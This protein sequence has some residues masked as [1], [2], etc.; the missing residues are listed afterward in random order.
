MEKILDFRCTYE[1]SSGF[2][3]WAA[4]V[5]VVTFPQAYTEH[6]MMM[7]LA[8]AVKKHNHA[9]LC[10]LPFC[11]TL[12]AEALGGKI[13][14]GDAMTGPRAASCSYRSL[15][16]IQ[17]L[18]EIDLEKDE[19]RR[20]KESLEACRQLEKQGE[21]VLFLVSGPFTIL[22]SLVDQEVLFR[23]VMKKKDLVLAVFQKLGRDIRKVMKLAEEAGVRY[24]S[25]G[26]PAGGVNIVGPKVAA[27]VAKEFT[28]SFLRE[29]DRELQP[30]TMVL[31]CPKTALA[32][33]GSG[34]AEWREWRLPEP[35]EYLEAA[36]YLNGEHDAWDVVGSA[37]I[38]AAGI[39]CTAVTDQKCGIRFAGQDC[40][41]HVGHRLEDGMFRELILCEKERL[42]ADIPGTDFIGAGATAQT[43]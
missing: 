29:T 11:H 9:V 42:G 36:V 34:V 40:I 1:N 8:V 14:L 18:P 19:C 20:L 25:Y 23:A 24:I 28:A 10:Q 3:E 17:E 43:R 4:Q 41:N 27:W 2:G 12:E 6:E 13:R 30:D 32:L 16:E 31:L 15:E 5:E 38:A 7:K 37:G 35:M 21:H 39:G 33:V 22:G 26:D